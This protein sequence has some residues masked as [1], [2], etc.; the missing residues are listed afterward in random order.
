VDG[1]GAANFMQALK[2][3]IENPLRLLS[4]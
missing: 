1:W 2:G 4:A 3:Y